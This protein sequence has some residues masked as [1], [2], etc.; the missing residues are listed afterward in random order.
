MLKAVSEPMRTSERSIVKV[1]VAMIAFVGMC[2]RGE[3]L[4]IISE[5]YNRCMHHIRTLDN[6][7]ANGRPPSRAKEYNCRD[8]V[9]T[10]LM[11][12]NINASMM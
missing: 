5:R 1:K 12:Q 6:V 10:M 2:V 4:Q 9:V 11:A 8:D 7:L 3:T